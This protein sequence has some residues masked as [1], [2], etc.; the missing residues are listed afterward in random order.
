MYSITGF[1]ANIEMFEDE[2][3]SITDELRQYNSMLTITSFNEVVNSFIP[4]DLNLKRQSKAFSPFMPEFD[5]DSLYHLSSIPALSINDFFT[6]VVKRGASKDMSLMIRPLTLYPRAN[7]HI[8]NAKIPFLVNQFLTEEKYPE[9]CL[10]QKF[11]DLKCEV[12]PIHTQVSINGFVH[13]KLSMTK[14]SEK[15]NDFCQ[16]NMT[17]FVSFRL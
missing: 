13:E 3:K 14:L 5:F 12:K 17:S 8:N 15:A 6:P 1:S 9:I 16:K 11:H 2:R 7:I 10:S 4:I